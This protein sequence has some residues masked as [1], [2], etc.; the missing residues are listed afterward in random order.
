MP[1]LIFFLSLTTNGHFPPNKNFHLELGSHRG[2]TNTYILVYTFAYTSYN[3]DVRMCTDTIWLNGFPLTIFLC[4][5]PLLQYLLIMYLQYQTNIFGKI[6]LN[7]FWKYSVCAL[8]LNYNLK[9]GIQGLQA[10]AFWAV[11]I[12]Y[13]QKKSRFKRER[14]G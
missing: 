12:N 11:N 3:I 5:T 1:N 6:Y 13:E 4:E 7:M 10:F 9:Q 2:S 14:M 8:K